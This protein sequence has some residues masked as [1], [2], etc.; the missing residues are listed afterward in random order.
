MLRQTVSGF[1]VEPFT[2]VFGNRRR[3][4]NAAE[5]MKTVPVMVNEK[6]TKPLATERLSTT[7]THNRPVNP[8]ND[9]SKQFNILV[10]RP[11]GYSFG[12]GPGA[13][14]DEVK[15]RA[16]V[17]MVD[18]G[19]LEMSHREIGPVHKLLTSTQELIRHLL[20]IPQEYEILFIQGGAHAQFSAVPL[21][22]GNK[23]R[24]VSLITGS[25]SEK[26]SKEQEKFAEIE[27]LRFKGPET[28]Q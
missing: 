15:Q 4:S 9:Y 6:Q 16:A 11:S 8:E 22:F 27:N 10:E 19:L 18:G 14:R 2:K 12:G 26:A 21:N 5:Q 28:Q 24:A 20:S 7:K 25:W 3:K 17:E 23:P 13:V 1:R